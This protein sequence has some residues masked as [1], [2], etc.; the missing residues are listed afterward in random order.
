MVGADLL[1]KSVVDV[2]DIFL[3]GG[4][5]FWTDEVVIICFEQSY[6]VSE[7]S[8]FVLVR[9][10]QNV[11]VLDQVLRYYQVVVH[12]EPHFFS[13]FAFE[14]PLD[15][16]VAF[17]KVDF[18]LSEEFAWWYS[19]IK[20]GIDWVYFFFDHQYFADKDGSSG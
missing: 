5:V 20:E 12:Y 19:W 6:S 15:G 9:A 13:A 14:A 2:V 4:Y 3:E 10:V 17:R 8:Y 7:V 16:V 18:S 11:V 1:N